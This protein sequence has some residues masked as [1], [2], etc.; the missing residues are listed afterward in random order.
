M[1]VCS[2]PGCTDRHEARGLC[3][4]HYARWRKHGTADDIRPSAEERF[5]SKVDKTDGC[6]FWTAYRDRN[7]YGKFGV[8]GRAGGMVSAH[9]VAYEMVVGPIP[10][11]LVLDHLCRNPGCVRP[12]HLDPVTHAENCRRGVAAEVNRARQRAVTH[13]PQ[14]HPYDEENTSYKKTGARRCKACA[15]AYANRNYPRRKASR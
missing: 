5:W 7:G 4:R 10:A 14:G 15:R 1:R 13:C 11:G 2:V 3:N 8:G 9:R 12:D 6:W